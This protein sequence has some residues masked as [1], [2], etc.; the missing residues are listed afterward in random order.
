MHGLI[1]ELLGQ[2]LT[3]NMV[4]ALVNT[5]QHGVTLQKT[6]ATLKKI[7]RKD[8]ELKKK[9]ISKSEGRGI[10]LQ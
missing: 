4:K 10:D 3:L 5:R 1:S 7:L 9:Y 8:I 2:L 6:L